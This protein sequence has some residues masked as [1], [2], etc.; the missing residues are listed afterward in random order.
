MI[1]RTEIENM[2]QATIS[3]SNHIMIR[4]RQA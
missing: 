1:L 4:Y 3:F 2:M